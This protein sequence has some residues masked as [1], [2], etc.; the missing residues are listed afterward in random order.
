MGNESENDLDIKKD[1][2]L[3]IQ[4]T[5]SEDNKEAAAES[6]AASSIETSVPEAENNEAEQTETE[7]TETEQTESEQTESEQTENET[8][9]DA[10]DNSNDEIEIISAETVPDDSDNNVLEPDNRKYHI[11]GGDIVRYIILAISIGIFA[12]AAM[13]LIPRLISYK[14]ESDNNKHIEEEVVSKGDEPITAA[15][16]DFSDWSAGDWR[17]TVFRRIHQ[18]DAAS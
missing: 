5:G 11:T 1:D 2:E 18:Q 14:K 15:E 10:S 7:Q 9:N 16:G 13:R 6:D 8:E 17:C 4:E 3:K 12:F